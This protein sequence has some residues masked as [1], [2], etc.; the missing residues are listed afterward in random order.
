ME[1]EILEELKLKGKLFKLMRRLQSIE[2]KD[3]YTLA[4]VFGNGESK[5][6]DIKPY[7]QSEVFKPLID[8]TIF[9]QIKNKGNYVAWL[10]DEIDLS[11]DT[12]WHIGEEVDMGTLESK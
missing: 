3:D 4:C 9:N 11:A 5:I 7:L 6:A 2:V 10:N 12:L 1:Q 8:K